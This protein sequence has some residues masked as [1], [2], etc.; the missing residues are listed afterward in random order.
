MPLARAALL[1]ATVGLALGACGSSTPTA[2]PPSPSPTFAEPVGSPPTYLGP[3]ASALEHVQGADDPTALLPPPAG[4]TPRFGWPALRSKVCANPGGPSCGDAHAHITVRLGVLGMPSF[5]SH[6]VPANRLVYYITTTGI[7][8]DSIVTGGIPG[9]QPPLPTWCQSSGFVNA[10]TGETIGGGVGPMPGQ[11]TPPAARYLGPITQ[12][13][14]IEGGNMIL[15]PP[16]VGTHSKANWEA[17]NRALCG[18]PERNSC[19]NQPVPT[20]EFANVISTLSSPNHVPPLHGRL[21]FVITRVG[22][23][24]APALGPINQTAGP[25]PEGPCESVSL[26]D[27]NSGHWVSTYNG[28]V[29]GSH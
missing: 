14:T 16:P 10:E 3:V 24:C 20:I 11:V 4:L 25:T 9:S 26:V 8:C 17:A 28:P 29:E 5:W 2:V 6:N 12:K 1:A 23:V 27:A 15:L 21:M 18:W 22:D 7:R 19:A 13:R